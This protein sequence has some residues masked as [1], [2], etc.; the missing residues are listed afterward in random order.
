MQTIL[1]K[2]YKS[3]SMVIIPVMLLL[4]LICKWPVMM[5]TAAML[6][7]IAIS[8][9]ATLLLHFMMWLSCKTNLQRGFAWMILFASIPV[10]SLVAACLFAAYVPGKVWFLLPLGIL[11]GYVGILSHGFSI[12]QVFNSNEN[13][14][15][16]LNRID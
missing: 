8:S 4:C 12:A 13:E 15:E 14:R 3:S 16:E 5:I 6:A 10:M 7:S 2:V 1:K 9:P 11:S